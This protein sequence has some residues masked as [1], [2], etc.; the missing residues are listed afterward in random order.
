MQGLS[1]FLLPERSFRSLLPVGFAGDLTPDPQKRLFDGFAEHGADHYRKC[2]C[3]VDVVSDRAETGVR[4]SDLVEVEQQVLE[5]ARQAFELPDGGDIAGPKPVEQAV[6]FGVVPALAGDA[7]LINALAAGGFEGIDRRGISAP[8]DKRFVSE[9]SHG[10]AASQ[11]ARITGRRLHAAQLFGPTH[12]MCRLP[13]RCVAKWGSGEAGVLRP[14][15]SW[16]RARPETLERSRLPGS[17]RARGQRSPPISCDM[18]PRR[19][20]HGGLVHWG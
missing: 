6:Q 19:E 13:I 17:S 7:V 15:W 8:I 2:R 16:T 11:R 18:R 10:N 3:A 12:L 1:L 20:G 9:G 14:P 5:R 4:V